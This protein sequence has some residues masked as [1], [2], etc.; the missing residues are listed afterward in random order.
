MNQ[1]LLMWFWKNFWMKWKSAL[2]CQNREFYMSLT[3][4]CRTIFINNKNKKQYNFCAMRTRNLC[5]V[6]AYCIS[7]QFNWSRLPIYG[8]GYFHIG[9]FAFWH[10]IIY[11]AIVDLAILIFRMALVWFF[12]WHFHPIFPQLLW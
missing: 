3:F 1:F 6:T 11:H 9:N 5:K 10:A 2:L 8:F 7:C 12:V 4:W